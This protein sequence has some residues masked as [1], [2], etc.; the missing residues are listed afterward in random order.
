MALVEW[1]R[2]SVVLFDSSCQNMGAA[3]GSSLQDLSTLCAKNRSGAMHV[4]TEKK[5]FSYIDPGARVLDVPPDCTPG[6]QC[7][8]SLLHNLLV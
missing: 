4:F 6:S 7:I 1:D 8:D 5:L 2:T 3:A